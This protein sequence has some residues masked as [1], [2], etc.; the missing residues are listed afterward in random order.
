MLK[1]NIVKR[2]SF[3]KYCNFFNLKKFLIILKLFKKIENLIKNIF[4]N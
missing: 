3:E 2:G 1:K 4:E